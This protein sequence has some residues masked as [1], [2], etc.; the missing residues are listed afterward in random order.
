MNVEETG[1]TRVAVIGAGLVGATFAYALMISGLVSEIVLVDADHE[2]AVGEAMDL[3]HGVPFV[4]NV[5]VWAGDYD[6][7]RDADI[8]VITAGANQKPGETRLDLV[9]RNLAILRD[10]I[11]RVTASENRGI[12]VVVANPV[13]VLAYAAWKL[14]GLPAGRV[15]GSGTILDTARFRHHIGRHFRVDPR[16]VHAYIVGEHG[17]SEVALWSSANIGNVPLEQFEAYD[18]AALAQIFEETRTAAYQIINRK[19]ATYYAIG[20]GV[21]RLVEAILHD[22]RSVLSV[23]TLVQGEYGV[24]GIY[25]SLPCVVGAGGVLAR[26]SPPI[27]SDEIA[28]LHASA[29]VLRATLAEVGLVRDG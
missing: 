13:D 8:T 26:L 12:I 1:T 14:S 9:K 16:S 20:L 22:Q 11:A 17:D 3:S 15:I 10:I 27:S 4:R 28:G 2:R 23:S 24:E 5:Q 29:G 18:E 19:R 25:L 21:T 7:V 6:D